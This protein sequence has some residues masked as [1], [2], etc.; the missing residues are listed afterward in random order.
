[1]TSLSTKTTYLLVTAVLTLALGMASDWG[2]RVTAPLRERQDRIALVD[3]KIQNQQA[4]LVARAVQTASIRQIANNCLPYD[5]TQAIAM[6]YPL[7]TET[8]ELSGLSAVSLSSAVVSG[9]VG[10]VRRMAVNLTATASRGCW[11]EFLMRFQAIELQQAIT[12]CELQPLEE[13]LLRGSLG[14]EVVCLRGAKFR[15]L[16]PERTPVVLE[17]SLFAMQDWFAD[18]TLVSLL[19][20][21]RSESVFAKSAT[22]GLPA[23]ETVVYL[24]PLASTPPSVLVGTLQRK[25]NQGEAWFMEHDSNEPSVVRVSEHFQISNI[26]G[27]VENVD[28]SGAEVVIDG[29]KFRVAIGETLNA[30]AELIDGD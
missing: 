21:P 12:T 23:V 10:E 28:S 25:G 13:G 17:K 11:A 20:P 2:K 18:R 7:L 16:L 4:V 15:T 14:F 26:V 27:T 29:Q 19:V 8:A 24:E 6:Y 1:M 9:E 5:E 3:E 22:E 30:P